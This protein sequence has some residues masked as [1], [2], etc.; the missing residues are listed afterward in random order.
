MPGAYVGLLTAKKV[1]HSCTNNAV[2]KT[3]A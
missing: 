1:K 3:A 2:A